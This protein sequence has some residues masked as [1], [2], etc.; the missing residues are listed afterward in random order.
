MSTF[1]IVSVGSEAAYSFEGVWELFKT[2]VVEGGM[3]S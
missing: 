3:L 2:G 1:V